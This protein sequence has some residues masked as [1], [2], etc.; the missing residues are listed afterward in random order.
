MEPFTRRGAELFCE[1]IPLERIAAEV[2]TPCYVYSRSAIEQRWRA[3]DGAFGKYP[4]LICYSVK[5]N[6]NLAILNL[7]ARL[8][9]GFDIVSGGE[10][11]RVMRAGG[12]PDKTVFSG[13]GKTRPEIRQALEAGVRCIDVESLEELQR[14]NQV[15]GELGHQAQVSIR[16]NPDIDANTHPF[17][18][19]GLNDAKF[20][21]D[22]QT[23]L[24]AYQTGAQMDNVLVTGIATHIGSQIVDN[25]PFVEALGRL[26][27][28]VEDLEEQHIT[29][30]HVDIGGGLGIRYRD[31]TPPD[32]A[33]YVQALIDTMRGRGFELPII[34]EPGRAII[35]GAGVL[36]TRV[37]YLKRTPTKHFAIVDAG[38]NDFLRP[39]LYNA[40]QDIV[41][42]TERSD[43]P[44][45]EVDVVGPV[46]E[47][48]D[49]LGEDRR[50]AIAEG[51]LLAIRD[52]GAYGSVMSSNYNARP[53]PAEVMV[54]GEEYYL[55]RH[56]ETI[57][58]LCSAES[59]L[60]G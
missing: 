42:V 54:D 16:V 13:V 20:G 52:A 36:L 19:T 51:D 47:N 56:R 49:V 6:S 3:F 46:C 35:G 48:T 10:L 27:R 38:M 7:L 34:V 5:A 11:E 17:I 1:E 57:D 60:P 22:T 24:T 37:E 14:V 28:L 2:A 26:L 8:G 31:E 45:I 40:W 43:R 41:T 23:A 50:L 33:S 21:M 18:A 12:D 15:A 30:E 4:H 39:A 29:I 59:V 25:V 58:E 9:S 55:I 44:M 32:I 53:R